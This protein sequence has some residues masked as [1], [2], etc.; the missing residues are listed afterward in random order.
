MAWRAERLA[1][2]LSA[3]APTAHA[4]AAIK[5]GQA[6]SMIVYDN[7]TRLYWLHLT[8]SS[9]YSCVAPKMSAETKIEK[10]Q[11]MQVSMLRTYRHPPEYNASCS[12]CPPP[13]WE[14]ARPRVRA[15][16][17][18]SPHSNESARAMCGGTTPCTLPD[19]QSP[20]A[21]MRATRRPV[22]PVCTRCPHGSARPRLCSAATASCTAS[23]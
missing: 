22:Q 18:V 2:H 20:P 1:C 4:A 17:R 8:C 6:S 16:E 3:T 23:S 11:C 5:Y 9:R 21:P 10:V 13:G 7:R 14:V 19:S 12:T 15:A